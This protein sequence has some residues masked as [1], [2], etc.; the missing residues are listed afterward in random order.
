MLSAQKS[1]PTAPINVRSLPRLTGNADID[2]AEVLS[3][4][5]LAVG[6][7]AKN[8]ALNDEKFADTLAFEHMSLSFSLWKQVASQW[9]TGL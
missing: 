8:V 9:P 6:F 7:R 5:R 3:L 1:L 2:V 4:F